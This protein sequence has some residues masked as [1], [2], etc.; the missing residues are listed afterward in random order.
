MG[1]RFGRARALAVDISPLRESVPYRA[2]WLGQ[3]VSLLGTQMRYVAVPFQVFQ[4][5]RSTVAVG[6]IGLVE[7]V[8]L[9][10]FSIAGGALADAL[11]RRK[12]IAVAQVILLIDSALLAAIS[13]GRD[14]SLLSI[15]LLTAVAGAAGAVDRPARAAMVPSLVEPGRLTSA[16]ALRQVVFQVSQIAGPAV[17]GLLIAVLGEVAWVYAID[18]ATFLASLLALR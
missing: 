7:V 4:I 8:P 5:T 10:I 1:R 16:M 14:P 6:L 18:A 15:F 11:D 3:V 12:I 17:G 13:W 2:L 9:I